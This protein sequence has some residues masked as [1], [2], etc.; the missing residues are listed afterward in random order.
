MSRLA[1]NPCQDGRAL[2]RRMLALVVVVIGVLAAYQNSFSGVFVFDDIQSI[3]E[4]PTIRRLWPPGMAL[5][6]PSGGG[7][8]VSGRPVVNFSLALNH[9][10]SG[11]QPWSYHGLNVVIHLG[12]ALVLL[13]WLR[14]TL[15]SPLVAAPFRANAAPIA[16]V[17]AVLW[18]VHPLQ[19]ESVT[20]VVQRAESLG[21]LFCLVTLYAFTRAVASARR[22]LW[23]TVSFAACALGMATKET[24]VVVPPLVV[25]YDRT[26]VSGSF[27]AVWA[28]HGRFHLALAGTWLLLAALVLGTSG[29]GGTVGFA[30]D[31]PAV[32]YALTQCV[33]IARYLRLAVWPQGQIFDY[34]TEPVT[35]WRVLMPALVMVVALIVA[36]GWA[37]VRRPRLGFAAVSFFALLAPSSSIVPV[38]TQIMAEH[39]MYLPLAGVVVV[40]AA[41]VVRMTGRLR[42]LL[43][44]SP[45]L[46]ML[47]VHRNE[48]YRSER[49]LW[50]ETAARQP[51]NARAH[52][53]LA[54]EL[55]KTGELDVALAHYDAAVR[56]RPNVAEAQQNL[57]NALVSAGRLDE[58]FD[59]YESAL[60]LQ[61]LSP[62][63][64]TNLANALDRAGRGT[65]ALAHY[66]AALQL[67]P[68]FAEAHYNAGLVLIRLRRFGE[69]AAQLAAAREAGMSGPSL[70]RTWAS[71]LA[72]DGRARDAVPHFER[73]LAARP[74]DADVRFN[75]ALAL[76]Q[77]G[78][79]AAA[80]RQLEEL[81][82]VRP[83][84][85]AARALLAELQRETGR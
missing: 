48:L 1:V 67:R 84:D 26:F 21:A 7:L 29:R 43:A 74:D 58:A 37:L 27:R 68:G 13:G 44:V 76:R 46:V 34:G 81:L 71:A 56:L 53:N 41:A 80:V 40:A 6:P 10:V 55:F 20:Y 75:L 54:N 61:P 35:D 38:A 82:R 62:E 17:G 33:A 59:H 24:A 4:N 78:E 32:T 57:A 8:T 51:G 45:A 49:D 69:A 23:L 5:S 79:P 85:A 22:R 28:R 11:T 15:Q 39:R 9:A 12:A 65:E 31:V 66:E 73:A 83:D 14:R 72:R 60:K 19:T 3:L 25:L 50:L 47:S 18:A 36:T 42:L 64:H 16:F 30:S 70:E 2:R 63:T 52:Y 77:S